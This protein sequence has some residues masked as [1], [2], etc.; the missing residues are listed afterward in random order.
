MRRNF[1]TTSCAVSPTFVDIRTVRG[2]ADLDPRMPAFVVAFLEAM[3]R[4]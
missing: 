3:W 2:R 4:Q 1:A